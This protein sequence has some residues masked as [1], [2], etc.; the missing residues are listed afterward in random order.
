MGSDVASLKRSVDAF[1]DPSGF[2][3]GDA[4]L[5]RYV[6]NGPTNA[7]DSLGLT[8]SEPEQG[9]PLPGSDSLHPADYTNKYHYVYN[10]FH[11]FGVISLSAPK[12]YSRKAEVVDFATKALAKQLDRWRDGRVCPD[13]STATYDDATEI[14]TYSVRVVRE[15][16][17]VWWAF[18]PMAPAGPLVL[19]ETPDASVFAGWPTPDWKFSL[20]DLSGTFRVEITEYIG[21]CIK[22]DE[23]LDVYDPLDELQKELQK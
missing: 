5:N 16:I 17:P 10:D 2:D 7:I 18:D 11:G 19:S 4:N 15:T 21:H 3:A 8:R 9:C 22:C 6:G 12:D 23:S 1:V 13:G 20:V 14:T